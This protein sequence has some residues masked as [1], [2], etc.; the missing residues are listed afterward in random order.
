MAAQEQNPRNLLEETAARL[1]D[2]VAGLAEG[3]RPFPDFLNMATIQAVELEL[4]SEQA[5]D[6]GCVVVLPDGEICELNLKTIPGPDGSSGVDQVEEYRELDLP[7]AQYI[8]CAGRA[9][10]AI[11]EEFQRRGMA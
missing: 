9:I 8:Q 10:A 6:L 2:V 3:L 5:T 4:T 11:C 1:H 7:A